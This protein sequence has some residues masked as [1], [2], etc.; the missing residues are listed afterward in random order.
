MTPFPVADLTDLLPF[1]QGRR[2]TQ[3]LVD[4]PGQ[5]KL[6]LA[7]LDGGAEVT[8]HAV[9]YEAGVLLLSGALEVMLGEAW[10]PAKPGQYLPV[11]I[12]VRHAVRALEPSH[13]LVVHARGLTA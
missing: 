2:T 12:G 1:E 5:T 4:L 9:P 13:F 8:P 6:V 3:T 11:P 7:A 10:H